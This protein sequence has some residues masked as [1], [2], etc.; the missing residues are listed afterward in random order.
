M[1][2]EKI[3]ALCKVNKLTQEE[4]AVN[5]GIKTG[6]LKYN[7]RHKNMVV[8]NLEKISKALNVPMSYWWEEVNNIMLEQKIEYEKTHK[9]TVD[10]LT[11]TITYFKNRCLKLED[12]NEE[13]KGK[14]KQAI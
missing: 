5:T 4:L 3:K 6:T 12:E 1:D 2:Y 10:E 9:K 11:D 7:L 8:S 14:G 13:L